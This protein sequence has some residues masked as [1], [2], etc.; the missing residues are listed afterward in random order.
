MNDHFPTEAA[1][2][3][4]IAESSYEIALNIEIDSAEMLAI[5]SDEL[6]EINGKRKQLEELRFTLT[7]PLDASK[8]RIM[9]LFRAPTE[10]LEQAETLLRKGV[11]TYQQAERA[12]ADAIRRAQELAIAAERAEADRQA[13]EAE[14]AERAA[15]AAAQAA[16][17]AAARHAAQQAAAEAAAAREAAQERVEL[18]DSAPALLVAQAP[19]AEGLSTRQTWKAEVTDINA[20]IDAAAK[21]GNE[22]LRAFL[23]ADTKALA[24]A[25]KAMRA[26]AR[27]PGVRIYTEESLAVRRTG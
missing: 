18:A 9:D 20:L 6:R 2:A 19:K 4:Q 26:Q 21:P 14:D 7:R 22:H 17:T 15:R 13:R 16:T 10:R 24:Q 12:K 5:A 27:I 25:A 3:A 1:Q 8:K 23:I 11:L